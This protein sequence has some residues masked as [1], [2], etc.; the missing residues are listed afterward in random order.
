MTEPRQPMPG[1]VQ[2][3]S[4]GECLTLLAE[5]QLGRVVVSGGVARSPLIRPVNYVFD[6]ATESV[7]FRTAR[8]SKFHALVHSR[9]ACFEIDDFDPHTGSGWSVIVA[10]VTEQVTQ[11]A[12][13]RRLE[14]AGL[15]S[16]AL[17][18]KP[19][20]LSIRAWTV[21]GRRITPPA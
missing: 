15:T 10:G 20:W 17:G 2:T 14:A 6:Q 4:R 9:R 3:L 5:H 11:P 18:E 12:E 16:W 13:L 1:H 19:H 8:G 21:S 7:V